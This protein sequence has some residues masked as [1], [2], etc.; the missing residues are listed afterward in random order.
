MTGRSSQRKGRAAEIELCTFLRDRGIDAHVGKPQSYGEEPDLTTNL[1]I[2]IECKRH[3]K[4]SVDK[5]MKQ[6]QA[7]ADRFGDGYATVIFRKSRQPWHIVLKL[8]DFLSLIE[9]R[10]EHE[11]I[12][13]DL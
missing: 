8:S 2:H 12:G 11:Q 6:S 3:E 9:G 13:R 4:L 10:S 5:W 1:N 7:D